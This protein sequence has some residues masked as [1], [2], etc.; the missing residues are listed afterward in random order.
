MS[1]HPTTGDRAM[2]ALREIFELAGAEIARINAETAA[3]GIGPMH[4]DVHR[5]AGIAGKFLYPCLSSI[6]PCSHG[7]CGCGEHCH[8]CTEHPCRYE[9]GEV[10]TELAA[11]GAFAVC[12]GLIGFQILRG[13]L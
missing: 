7:D 11:W 2:E 10:F 9:A 6:G 13:L 12:T 3:T 1:S 8:E 4:H 5:I